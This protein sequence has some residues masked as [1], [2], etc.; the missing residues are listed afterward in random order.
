[1]NALKELCLTL[2]DAI[3]CGD[4]SG[5]VRAWLRVVR[6]QVD[7][8]ARV[9][10]TGAAVEEAGEQTAPA[11]PVGLPAQAQAEMANRPAPAEAQTA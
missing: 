7:V 10:L 8:E 5:H 3:C 6:G 9:V 4:L 1:M 2:W 11:R